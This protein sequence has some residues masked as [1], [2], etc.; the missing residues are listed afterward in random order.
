YAEQF[1]LQDLAE[2]AGISTKQLSKILSRLTGM[3]YPNYLNH[4][5]MSKALEALKYSDRSITDI[6]FDVGY[7]DSNYFSSKFKKVFNATPREVRLGTEIRNQN[8]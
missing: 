2:Q 4:I 7:Q 1:N 6:A 8:V 3:S 5:R